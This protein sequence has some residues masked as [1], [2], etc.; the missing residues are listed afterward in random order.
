M[1][2]FDSSK[3]Y[4]EQEDVYFNDGREVELQ[5]FVCSRPSLEKLKG[6]PQEVLAAIDEFGRQRKYLMNIGSEKGAIVADLIAS[7]KPKIMVELGGYVGYSAVLFGDALR[8]AG[9]ERFICIEKNPE[10]AA[11]ARSMVELAGLSSIVEIHVGSADETLK[12]LH[13][14]GVLESIDL[15]FLDHVKPAYL[16]DLKTCENLQLVRPG[17]VL[18]ADNVIKPGNPPYLDQGHRVIGAD[19]HRL[20]PA[21]VSVALSQ[22]Y[23]LPEPCD[24]EL[25]TLSTHT[26]AYVTS[27]LQII[28]AEKVDLWVSVSD[29]NAAIQ[30]AQ[31][32]QLIENC[33]NTRVIQLQESQVEMLHNKALFMN[34]VH[35][36]GLRAPET[37]T[38]L[39]A[40]ELIEFL[41]ARG[42][43]SLSIS[44]GTQYLVKPVDINDIARFGMAL[45][46]RDIE[47][48]TL[49]AISTIPFKDG[50]RVP[51]F[52]IQ[53]YIQGREYCTHALVIGGQVRA[54]VACPSASVLMHYSALSPSSH[55]SQ[56][57]LHFTRSIIEKDSTDWTGHLSFDFIVRSKASSNL[58][59][60]QHA[61]IYP[62]ECNPRVHTAVVLFNETP[63]LVEDYLS[64]L[65]PGV[66]H[67]PVEPRYPRTYRKYY[68]LGQDFVELAML[69][70]IRALLMPNGG[71][72]SIQQSWCKFW[73]HLCH[74]KDATFEVSD[75]W[76]FWWLYHV[77]WPVQFAW[78]LRTTRWQ[79]IN[80]STGKVFK[81]A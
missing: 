29:V 66:A 22:F 80:V 12:R 10:F 69:P 6:S 39:S 28:K 72:T 56:K 24:T 51:S 52:Q 77:Y 62:I 45:V 17:S 50:N 33:T 61:E 65:E 76:P 54:F 78:S 64:V 38:V 67:Q 63:G 18:A 46:P 36:I 59:E 58:E 81:A 31:A 4:A 60:D 40:A 20:S 5:R 25:E 13:S 11:V 41:S 49:Q 30:D 15:L 3:A 79:M 16:P 53:E 47:Q 8:S 19:T 55:L 73:H 43:L 2:G 21:R 34:H 27:L 35:S 7:L 42:G 14:S 37:K 44:G 71:D 48:D 26:T 32:R 23:V 57:M 68:W 1:A 74:W 75:P 9:G 70:T